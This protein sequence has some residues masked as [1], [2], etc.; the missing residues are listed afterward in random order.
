ME[1]EVWVDYLFSEKPVQPGH[2][3]YHIDYGGRGGCDELYDLRDPKRETFAGTLRE[4]C[5]PDD[6]DPPA[7][8]SVCG[9]HLAGTQPTNRLETQFSR[10]MD[11]I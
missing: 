1:T 11:A 6:D 3:K 9:S 4:V 10:I 7:K 2:W 5:S 8:I